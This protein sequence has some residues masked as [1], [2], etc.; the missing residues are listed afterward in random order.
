MARHDP[1]SDLLTRIRNAK[2]AKHKY[3]DIDVSKLKLSILKVFQDQGFIENYIVN[4]EKRQVR[5]FLRY[6]EGRRPVIQGLVRKSKPGLR[7][8]L[9]SKDIPRVLGGMGVA[10]M[11][12]SKGILDGETARNHNLGGEI[13]CLIW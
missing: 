10:I 12:T 1:V 11:S 13:L 7:R 2:D 3:V 9:G 4:D 6:T 8:Y 5:I